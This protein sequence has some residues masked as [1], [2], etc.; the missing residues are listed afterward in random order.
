MR[1][2]A[3]RAA[4]LG[5]VLLFACSAQ[6]E[7]APE[8]DAQEQPARAV[9]AHGLRPGGDTSVPLGPSP[10]FVLPAANLD[11]AGK[12]V[13]YAGKA[14]AT[15]PWVRAPTLTDARDGLGPLYHA[16]SCLACHVKG[17]RGPSADASESSRATLVRLS[18]PGHGPHG[19]PIPDPIYGTQLQPQS[20]SLSHQLRGQTGAERYEGVAIEAEVRITWTVR[21][22]AY[23]DGTTLELRVPKLD[24]NRWGYGPLGADTRASL[25]HTPSLAGVGL[26][27]LIPQSD[28]DR[29]A[30]PDDED[31]DGISGRV[32]RVWDP[33][34][35]T[36][37]PGR[38]GLKANQ[39]SVRVQVAGALSGDMGLSSPV[40]PGQPCTALQPRCLA[41]PTGND[42]EGF[43]VPEH[44]LA[45]MVFFTQ[46]IGVP[47]RR[48]ADDPLVLR[49]QEL[50]D[51]VG[52]DDC[53]TPRHVTGVDERLPHLSGQDIWPYSDLLLH[54][55]GAEL[56]DGREDF[57]A[58]GQ[59]W[60]TPPLWG[61]GL[62]R[63]MLAR[64]GFL[65]DARART[66]EEAV[67]WHDGEA[68]ASRVRFTNLRAED[69][70]ALTAFV[71]SL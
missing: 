1:L 17:G 22:F 30:D 10:S 28:L 50:F 36:T 26:L 62:A 44:M 18:R 70:R 42:A 13:F 55:M 52:C 23:P 5:V 25:R 4:S 11:D 34:T 15:Q 69:R 59:E 14:L 38:F 8:Q 66:V 24:F 49:G 56:A 6:S 3:Y 65:H 48:R 64:V 61:V 35:N 27:E 32:N 43:E 29:I 21:S 63:A 40:F 31:G 71:R 16:R 12:S 2:R 54:D 67:V 7:T 9:V 41:A 39:P 60:R 20:T 47:Q 37:R 19:E 53:H 51:A 58:T 57:L 45:S 68:R 33:E 46:S